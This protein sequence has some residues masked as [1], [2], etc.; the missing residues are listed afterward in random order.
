MYKTY[1]S[2]IAQEI[3]ER[4]HQK[5]WNLYK[6]FYILVL[7]QDEIIRRYLA[8]SLEVN[9]RYLMLPVTTD[10]RNPKQVIETLQIFKQNL[11]IDMP[12]IR[13]GHE[14][15]PLTG[16]IPKE[17]L[18]KLI[19]PE[20]KDVSYLTFMKSLDSIMQLNN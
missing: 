19:T 11:N 3:L 2:E 7:G 8:K 14:L 1:S 10:P 12:T 15:H 16:I 4:F 9:E 6:S 20:V 5:G 13:V 17:N 18:V